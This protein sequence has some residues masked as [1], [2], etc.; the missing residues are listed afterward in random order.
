MIADLRDRRL[1][2][3]RT[4]NLIRMAFPLPLRQGLLIGSCF[5]TDRHDPIA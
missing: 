4:K 2:D 1:K 3:V 5:F